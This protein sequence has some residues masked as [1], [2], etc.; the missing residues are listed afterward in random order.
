MANI[1]NVNKTTILN[2]AKKIGHN[3]SQYKNNIRKLNNEQIEYINRN[4][5]LKNSKVLAQEFSCS[6][7]LISKI[8]M[9]NNKN[10]KYH[11]NYY[12]D[13]NYFENIDTP[14]KAYYLGFIAADGCVYKRKN[15]V[16]SQKWLSIKIN[17]K[18]EELLIKFLA[19][20]NSGNIIHRNSRKCKYYISVY[21][22]M[23]IVSDK[24]CNDL[25]KYNILP[26]KTYSYKPTYLPDNLIFHFIRGYF[27]GDGSISCSKKQYYKP[28]SYNITFTGNKDTMTYFKYLLSNYDIKG[29]LHKDTR[30]GNTYDLHISNTKSKY[31]FIN[32]IYEDC[33][34][35]CLYRKKN[36]S[37]KFIKAVL[38]NKTKRVKI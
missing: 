1:Y 35:L 2:Y 20:L 15:N 3:T 36:L 10:G 32:L 11:Y 18:D 29:V 8:W 38:D 31:K 19:Y 26:N 33:K 34:D 13:F 25:Y 22:N 6:K 24:L 5:D 37:D 23:Q 30:K 27:D 14:D 12:S 7:E 21:S 9:E 28:S 4:Y 16:N 17:Q